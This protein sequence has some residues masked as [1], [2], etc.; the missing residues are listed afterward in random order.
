MSEYFIFEKGVKVLE[1]E[2]EIDTK[3]FIKKLKDTLEE[4]NYLVIESKKFIVELTKTHIQEVYL[5]DIY[6]ELD[7]GVYV[8]F[9]T[10]IIFDK[11]IPELRK[12]EKVEEIEFVELTPVGVSSMKTIIKFISVTGFFLP[13]YVYGDA[14]MIDRLLSKLFV[15]VKKYS[16]TVEY[17][18]KAK[19]LIEETKKIIEDVYHSI[20]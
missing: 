4:N 9:Y 3:E 13:Q 8:K 11:K 16:K 17:R 1:E 15:F 2:G 10:L 14:T 6:K 12:E 19:N 7:K 18:E 5:F 20:K